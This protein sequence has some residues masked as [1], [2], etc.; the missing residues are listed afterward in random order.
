MSE[1]NVWSNLSKSLVPKATAPKPKAE[2]TSNLEELFKMSSLESYALEL[3]KAVL[4]MERNCPKEINTPFKG[5]CLEITAS[6]KYFIFGSVEGRLAVIEK[7]TKEILHDLLLPS[8]TIY[9]IALY[10]NDEEILA[11]G[12]D[13]IIRKF[14]FASLEETKQYIGHTKEINSIVLSANEQNIFSASDDCTVR[15]W[16]EFEDALHCALHSR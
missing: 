7:T 11:A 4:M 13:G 6:G 12:K 10:G 8:G 2:V 3:K 1:G 16:S 15:S 9:T 5:N 14:D